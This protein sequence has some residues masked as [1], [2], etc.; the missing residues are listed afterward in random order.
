VANT[1]KLKSIGQV[2]VLKIGVC[3]FETATHKKE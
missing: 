3:W 1:G 2:P